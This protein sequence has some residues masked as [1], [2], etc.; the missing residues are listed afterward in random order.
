MHAEREN[1]PLQVIVVGGA[2]GGAVTALLLARDGANVTL[3][4]KVPEPRA[5]GAGIAL[6][7]NG[8]V[9]LEH[10]GLGPA[11]ARHGCPVPAPRVVDGR[12]RELLRPHGPPP[13]ALMIRRSD[14]QAVLLDAL[15]ADHRISLQLGV[16]VVAARPDGSVVTRRDDR[17]RTLHADLVV[18]ADGVHSRVRDGGEFGARVGKPGPRYVRALVGLG[19][20]R[21]EEAWTREGLF[22]SFAVPAGTYVYASA[23]GPAAPLLRE[24]GDLRAWKAAWA[25]AYA[26]AAEILAGISDWDQLLVNDVIRVDCRHYFDGRLVLVG[27]AAHAMAPNVG[28]GG[29][30]AIVDAAVLGAALRQQTDVPEALAIY[31][32]RRRPAVRKVADAAARLG[33]LA[34]WTHPLARLLRDRVLMPIANRTMGDGA[35]HTVLQ[36]SPGTLAALCSAPS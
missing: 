22:G 11:L 27:D 3:L 4:E 13:R 9:V 20:A 34:G 12:G 1:H 32:A 31:D 29:N 2:I 25:R 26:P 16:E 21:G 18:G 28:Q 5:V 24:R 36:E 30:S 17:V 10:L 7:E 35:V 23:H 33:A 15:L 6:A 8:L 14:L 19:L